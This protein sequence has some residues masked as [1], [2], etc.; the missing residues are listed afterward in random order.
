MQKLPNSELTYM[1][2]YTLFSIPHLTSGY[3]NSRKK[4]AWKEMIWISEESKNEWHKI[5]G[6]TYKWTQ[7]RDWRLISD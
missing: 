1:M 5:I 7:S 3:E 2:A 6:N 4:T